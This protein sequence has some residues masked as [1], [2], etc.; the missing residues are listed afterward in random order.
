M[1]A[2]VPSPPMDPSPPALPRLQSATPAT[3]T[4]RSATTS[5]L[6]ASMRNILAK[7]TTPILEVCHDRPNHPTNCNRPWR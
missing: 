5:A 1:N 3:N 6:L 4:K 2:L 7:I